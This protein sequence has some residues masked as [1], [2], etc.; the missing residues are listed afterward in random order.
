LGDTYAVQICKA[1]RA[2]ITT[3]C[4]A[5]HQ[6][7]PNILEQWLANKTPE[8]GTQWLSNANNINLV[9]VECDAV[10]TAG[11]V[12]RAGAILLNYVAPTARFRGV[13]SALLAAMEAAARKNG[14]A[15]CALDSTLTAQRFYKKHGYVDSGPPREKHGLRTFPMAKVL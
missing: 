15:R 6:G 3:L 2:S 5:D 7:D 9:A 8:N 11:C 4:S 1:I 13:S 14:N 10:V 12:T